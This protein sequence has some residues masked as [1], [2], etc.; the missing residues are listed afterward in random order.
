MTP[1][2]A[3]ADWSAVLKEILVAAGILLAWVAVSTVVL[4]F[5]P[6]PGALVASTV[7]VLPVI[8]HVWRPHRRQAWDQLSQLNVRRLPGSWRWI[9]VVALTGVWAISLNV[10][11]DQL[12]PL[13]DP[14]LDPFAEYAER[15]GWIAVAILTVGLAPL[16]EEFV[17]RGWIQGALQRVTSPPTAIFISAVLFALPHLRP[18]GLPLYVAMGAVCGWAVWKTGSIWAGVVLHAAYNGALLLASAAQQRGIAGLSLEMQLSPTAIVLISL[19][20]VCSL[21]GVVVLLRRE[22][23]VVGADHEVR[24][25]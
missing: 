13:A 14:P 11:Y 3:Q 19:A 6:V 12:L 4:L 15:G 1:R 24:G 25:S 2:Q 18:D 20:G 8:V 23:G 21:A 7:T 10:I 5:P 9:G 22:P 16:I 17:F